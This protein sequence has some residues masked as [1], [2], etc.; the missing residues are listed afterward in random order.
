M[1]DKDMIET[2]LRVRYAET[3]AMGIVYHTNYIIWF[4]VGRGEYMRKKGRDYGEFEAAG[5]YLPVIEVDA[6]FLAPARYE[7]VV[8]VR[9][10]MEELRSR[11]ITFYYEVV[12]KETGQVL[13]TG[14][15]KHFC[16]DRDGRVRKFPQKA[17]EVLL[18]DRNTDAGA[19]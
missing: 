13:A 1:S 7:D 12:M 17:G 19:T 5:F 2:T 9:T 11:S 3:D 6:R 18:T 10:S 14:H 4:E 8:V 15:T 16:T